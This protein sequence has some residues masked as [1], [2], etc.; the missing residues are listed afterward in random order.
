MGQTA[1]ALDENDVTSNTN[2]MFY[3]NQTSSKPDGGKIDHILATWFG[4]WDK[5]EMHHGY[6]QCRYTVIRWS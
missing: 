4:D 2:I 1:S 5:L 6:V 3:T